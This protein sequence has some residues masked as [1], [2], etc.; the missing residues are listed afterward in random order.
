MAELA[1]L[2]ATVSA[3]EE[4]NAQLREE[5]AQLRATQA[6]LAWRAPIEFRLTPSEETLL[7]RLAKGGRVHKEQ[8][9][10]ALYSA[11]IDT[12]P[13]EI[14]IVD[15]LICKLR[16]KLKPFDLEIETDRGFGYALR[17]SDVS[18]LAQ[19]PHTQKVL[20]HG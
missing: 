4:E 14:K 12:D 9:Y 2:R 10:Q 11:R 17:A 1:L 5:I 15:V 6:D 16:G 13:P 3:L 8:L 18:R 20:S 7:G 19:W